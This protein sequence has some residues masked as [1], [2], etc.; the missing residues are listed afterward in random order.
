AVNA[1]DAE[2]V[3]PAELL[4]TLRWAADYYHHPIGE[5][6]SHAL[7]GLLRK[8]RP[9]EPT[10]EPRWRLSASGRAAAPPERAARQR[11]VLERLARGPATA[12]ELRRDG[13]TA[14]TL[15]RLAEA[16][17]IVDADQPFEAEAGTVDGAT[18]AEPRPEPELFRR[19][20]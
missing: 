20:E 12:G 8:G 19:T 4:A 14:A 5:V 7:P 6:L 11:A 3:L 2:P 1:L 9:V 15:R 18:H 16:G 10:P 13:A 17:W